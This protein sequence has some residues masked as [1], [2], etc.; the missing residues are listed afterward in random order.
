M[1]KHQEYRKVSIGPTDLL[2][3]G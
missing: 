1:V 3:N 2:K